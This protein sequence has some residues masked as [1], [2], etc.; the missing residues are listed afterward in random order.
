MSPDSRKPSTEFI[1]A[2]YTEKGIGG[3]SRTN[4]ATSFRQFASVGGKKPIAKI[5]RN[6]MIE[7][8]DQ[9]RKGDGKHGRSISYKTV[10]KKLSD[11]RT[12][13]AWCQENYNLIATNP[14]ESFTPECPRKNVTKGK[15]AGVH[16]RLESLTQYSTARCSAA[17]NR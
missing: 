13:L 4:K 1:E 12:F 2:Y 9:I 10:N 11:I 14:A 3:K 8:H 5:D 6:D 16:S 17:A 15:N 7:F